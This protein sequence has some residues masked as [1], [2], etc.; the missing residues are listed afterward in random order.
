MGSHMIEGLER[1]MGQ[2]T[3]LAKIPEGSLGDDEVGMGRHAKVRSAVANYHAATIAGPRPMG[4]LAIGA[5]DPAV[6]TG[7]GERKVPP[8]AATP[9]Q[10][11]GEKWNRKPL[12]LQDSAHEAIEAVRDD[13]HD[14]A[15]PRAEAQESMEAGV[16]PDFANLIVELFGRG[17]QERHLAPHALAR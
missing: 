5:C 1:S 4:A 2:P 12:A 7:I 6:G 14:H 9:L 11:I 3:A 16:D 13:G 17:A 15:L 10:P 8:I